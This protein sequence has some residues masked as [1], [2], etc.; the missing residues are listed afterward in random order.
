[1]NFDDYRALPAMNW[2]RLKDIHTSPKLFKFREDHPRKDTASLSNGRLIHM[3]VLEPE[4]F[5]ATVAVKPEGMSLAKKDGKAWKA[6]QEGKQI[7]DPVVVLCA[8]AVL[9]DPEASKLITLCR[10]EQTVQ[11]VDQYTG[12]HCKARLDMLGEDFFGDLKTCRDLQWFADW[13]N[14]DAPRKLD[15]EK[16]LYYGQTAWYHNGAVASEVMPHDGETYLVVVETQEPYDVAVLRASQGTM[17]KGRVL[18]RSLLGLWQQCSEV[19]LW[20]GISPTVTDW[21][22]SSWAAGTYSKAEDLG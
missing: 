3:A 21:E 7:A 8:N 13:N 6:S 15:A 17:D 22:L 19:D 12:A 1:V 10:T 9:A 11:W 5:A 14:D 18:C 2:S 20:P 16:M 4:R